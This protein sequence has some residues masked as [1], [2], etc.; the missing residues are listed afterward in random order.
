[1]NT[2]NT[3]NTQTTARLMRYSDAT[4]IRAATADE[5]EASIDAARRDGGAGVIIVDGI[6]CYVEE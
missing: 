6:R 4:T 1:M 2:Q 3:Q 5:L